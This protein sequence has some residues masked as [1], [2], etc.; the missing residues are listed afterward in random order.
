MG[1]AHEEPSQARFP[2][3]AT[4]HQHHLDLIHRPQRPRRGPLALGEVEVQ[5]VFRTRGNFLVRTMNLEVCRPEDGVGES[6][7]RVV[8][9]VKLRQ[10]G[11]L[12]DLR[13]QRGEL[14]AGEVKLLR[15]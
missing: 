6:Q 12:A 4:A 7:R 5:D 11:E 10:L 1:F 8:V 9:E 15:R 14:V 13:R 2:R 3:P